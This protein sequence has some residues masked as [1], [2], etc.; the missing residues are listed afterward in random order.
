[1]ERSVRAPQDAANLHRIR[2]FYGD[3]HLICMEHLP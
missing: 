2:D 3:F 1:M